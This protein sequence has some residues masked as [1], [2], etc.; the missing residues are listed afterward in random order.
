MTV[1]ETE[2]IV[3]RRPLRKE[4]DA[5][6]PVVGMILVLAISIVG[7][8]AIL[9]WGLPAIDEMKANVEHRS[10]EAQFEELD[11]SI[12]ELVA[13]TTE[14]T[15]KRWQPSLNRGQILVANNTEGWLYATEL[16]N[17]SADHD[18]V[19]TDFDDGDRVFQI[20]YRGSAPYISNVVVQA[21]LVDDS[22]SPTQLRVSTTSGGTTQMVA[23][24]LPTWSSSDAIRTFYLR[25]A[26]AD[27]PIT[28]A[29]FK[30][31]IYTNGTLLA[32]AWYV[33]T[34]R[35]DY[36]LEAGLGVK[37]VIENNGAVL[38]GDGNGF[39]LLNTPPLPPQTNTTG[40]TRFFARAVV[41]NG[42]GSFAG[43][44]RFDVLVTLYT[45]STLA[46]YDCATADFADCVESSKVFIFGTYQSPWYA[47]LTS[48]GRGYQFTQTTNEGVTYL[49]DREGYMGYTLLQS[50]VQ[51][52]ATG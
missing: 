28:N 21:Y 51:L 41:M 15:A 12:K 46:S 22:T 24:D 11:S 27:M 1:R 35:I 43:D 33:P 9:Y 37:Q 40:V 5:V 4:E 26:T 17:S 45:T 13:G 3:H 25:T 19:W 49:V 48:A 30:F 47:Y 39:A 6:S 18:F 31:K 52:V 23:A 44:D 14:K 50:D 29:T 8:A 34:G 20:K 32:E 16:Y 10:V 7:I 36:R 42:S 38:T 2:R